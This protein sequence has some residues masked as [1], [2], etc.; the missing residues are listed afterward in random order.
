MK[1]IL[2]VTVMCVSVLCGYAQRKVE[3]IVESRNFVWY[4]IRENGLVGVGNTGG[5]MLIEAKYDSIY[6]DSLRISGTH[7]YYF[8]VRTNGMEGIANKDG[9]MLFLPNKFEKVTYHW[10][11]W[12]KNVTSC[13]FCAVKDGFMGIYDSKGNEVFAPNKYKWVDTNKALE[14]DVSKAKFF[15]FKENDYMGICDKEGNV[16][17]PADKY[18]TVWVE[19]NEEQTEIH[20]YRVWKGKGKDRF[21]GI[22]DVYG[23]EIIPP[24]KYQYN[25]FRSGNEKY[26]FYYIVEK[27]GFKGICDELGNEIIPPTKYVY[28][29]RLG[30]KEDGFYYEISKNDCSGVIDESGKEIVF[31][32]KY[33]S[34]CRHGDKEEG[35]YYGVE[36][37]GYEGA[38]NMQGVEVVP[39]KYKNLIYS[40]GTFKYSNNGENFISLNI[41]LNGGRAS[42][43]NNYNT[44]SSSTSSNQSSSSS[45]SGYVPQIIYTGGNIDVGTGGVIG[46]ASTSTPTTRTCSVCQGT[47]KDLTPSTVAQYGQTTYQYCDICK[48]TGTPHY[49][50]VCPSCLGRKTVNY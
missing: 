31:P 16:I 9:N 30:N 41:G 39:C 32:N 43:E 27:D 20:Y 29:H 5:K 47:G 24:T 45:G 6:V 33:E 36:K 18:N 26:G 7:E 11:G 3:R 14:G 8:R 13:Y 40:V 44:S 42:S 17:F 37:D 23:I 22:C 2:L 10:T 46:G 15:M 49:H 4:K 48:S 21:A 12:Y 38:C 19:T 28:I 25:V 1:K 35:F 50:K 34:V